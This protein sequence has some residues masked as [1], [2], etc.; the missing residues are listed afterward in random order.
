M[1][2]GHDQKHVAYDG[3]DAT[4]ARTW[5]TPI[6]QRKCNHFILT[7]EEKVRATEI[8]ETTMM[9]SCSSIQ[10]RKKYYE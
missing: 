7:F 5:K 3:W 10:H 8:L 4:L 6:Q 2:K 9:A 1:P